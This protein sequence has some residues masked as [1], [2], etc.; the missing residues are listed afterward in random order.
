MKIFINFANDRYQKEQDF[1]L[2]TAKMFGNF[3]KIIGY[4][5]S[6]IDE[7]FY[8]QNENILKI[9]RGAGLWLWK[10]YFILKTLNES[11]EG[12]YVFYLDSGFFMTKKIDWLIEAL[13]KGSQDIMSFQTYYPEIQWTKK[14]LLQKMGCDSEEFLRSNQFLGGICL[15]RNSKA[16][17][18]FF[19]EFIRLASELENIEDAKPSE[20]QYPEFIENRHDQSIYSLLCKKAGLVP[21]RTPFVFGEKGAAYAV[22]KKTSLVYK[23]EMTFNFS[24]FSNSDYPTMLHVNKPFRFFGFNMNLFFV[25][26]IYLK[27]LNVLPFEST[28]YNFLLK[29]GTQ[30]L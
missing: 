29:L 21:F 26:Y 18:K 6:D 3:D 13:N 16:S 19:S 23:R 24:D 11:S 9:K 30:G 2:K 4:G 17:R 25:S 8:Q 15:V 22:M 10:P 1:A 28:L 5:P 7:Q 27:L 14:S 20:M 12:D